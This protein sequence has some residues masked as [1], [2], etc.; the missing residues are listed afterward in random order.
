M[1]THT[2]T[3]SLSLSE[4]LSDSRVV[5][6]GS[7]LSLSYS[8]VYDSMSLVVWLC[9]YALLLKDAAISAQNFFHGKKP[10]VG[11]ANCTLRYA[12]ETIRFLSERE[13]ID[14]MPVVYEELLRDPVQPVADVLAFYGIS[15]DAHAYRS[16]EKAYADLK[17]DRV[18][19]L[20][21][22]LRSG[23]HH[24]DAEIIASAFARASWKLWYAR[25][26]EDAVECTKHAHQ[27]RYA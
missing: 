2:R 5:F 7:L 15:Q 27:S 6:I 10:Y 1:N 14:W 11:Y 18:K 25:I 23:T 4:Y 16:A 9:V 20:G 26:V 24:H 19:S 3:L 17:V 22:V 8:P 21:M 13:D 12:A